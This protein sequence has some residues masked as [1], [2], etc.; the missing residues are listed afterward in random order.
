MNAYF[1]ILIEGIIL[2]TCIIAFLWF[3]L[4]D[5]EGYK[6]LSQEGVSISSEEL[7]GDKKKTVIGRYFNNR[8]K[9]YQW[10][11]SRMTDNYKYILAVYKKLNDDIEKKQAVPPSAEWLL[12]NFYVIDE[13]VQVIKRDLDKRSYLRLPILN[14]GPSKGHT[15]IYALAKDLVDQTNG[16]VD[17]KKFLH[18][19]EEYQSH[20]VLLEREIVAV[21]MMLKLALIEKIRHEC[22]NIQSIQIQWHKADKIFEEWLE[23]EDLDTKGITKLLSDN[24]RDINEEN[25][26]FIDHLFYHLRRSGRSYAGIIKAMDENF[27]KQGSTTE[28]IIQNEHNIQSMMTVSMS[29]CITSLHYF[30]SLNWADIFDTISFVELILKHDPDGT[31]PDMDPPTRSYYKTKVEELALRYNVSE[32]YI[33]NLAVQMALDAY[34]Q[35]DV[36]NMCETKYQKTWH[37]GHYLIGTGI[38]V[39][40]T[41]L[42]KTDSSS[43]TAEK[44]SGLRNFG[45]LYIGSV[46]LIT[47][48]LIGTAVQYSVISTTSDV[49]F[50]SLLAIIAVLIPASEIAVKMVNFV[51]SH[52]LKPS[53]FPKLELKDGIPES[54]ST[55][56]AVPTLIPNENRLKELLE[57][58]ENH[59]LSNREE[60]LYF[61]LI[62]A[63]RDSDEGQREDDDR[64]IG[65]A[66][67]GIKELNEKYPNGKKD[68]FY[69]FHRRSQFNEKNN[70]WIGWERKRGAIIEF[71]DL[72]LG[73]QD[74]S[75]AYSSSEKPPFLNTKYIITLD[76][77]T[78]LPNGMAKKM[79]GAM[80][81]P[82][83][84]PVIDTERGVV[85][86]GFGLM[87]PKIEVDNESSNKTHFARIFTGQ[88]GIDPYTFAVSDV[89]QD[90]FGEG[91]YNGKGIYDLRVF[92]SAMKDAICDDTVLSHDLLEGSYVRTGLVTD[93]KLI[94]SYPLRYNS[95]S[96]R[97]HRWVRGDWQ[98]IKFL[99]RKICNRHGSKIANPLS[100]LSRWKI[101]DNLRRSLITVSLMVLVFLSF[102]ILPGSI[103]FW[104]GFFLVTLAFPLIIG[105]IGY[106]ISLRFQFERIKN[107]MPL[108]HGIKALFMQFL[109]SFVFLPYQA[110]L[111]IKAISVTWVRVFIT[112]KNLLEWVTSDDIEKSQRNDLESYFLNMR[113]S[114]LQGLIVFLLT[115]FFKPELMLLGLLFFGAWLIAPVIAYWISKD[116]CALQ[117]K[118][119]EN[120]RH[121]L[122][123]IAR[124]TWRFFEEFTSIH[125][126]YL[127]PDNYQ[128][129]PPRCMALRTSP[130]NIGLGLMAVLCARDF[131][132][133][134]TCE[135]MNL[136]EKTIT[137]IEKM[138]KWNGHLYNWY[139][140]QTLRPLK[141]QY[142]STVDSG[143][144][145]CYLV[146]VSEG[147]KN[148]LDCPIVDVQFS[149]GIRDTLYC[150]GKEGYAAY[151]KVRA[152]HGFP[153][154]GQTNLKLWNQ[155]LNELLLG[156]G[157][158]DIPKGNWRTK[159]EQM[160]KTFKKDLQQ[161]RPGVEVME[162]VPDELLQK[163]LGSNFSDNMTELLGMLEHNS[164]LNNLAMVY[165]AK[166]RCVNRLISAIENSQTGDFTEGLAWLF[167]LEDKLNKVIK[168]TKQFIKRYRALIERINALSDA[169][170]FSPLYDTKR[171][172]F[173]IG[174]N[175]EENK[176]SNSYYDLLASEARQTSYICVAQGKIP[177]LHWYKLERSLTVMD[178][179]KGLISWTGTMFEYLM[180]L[181][182]MKSYK[183]TLLDETYSFVIRSQ[184]KYGHQK[185]M[186]WG[187]SESGFNSL[188][189][190]SD[191]QY[192]AIGVPWL[193][194][195]RGL[196]EDAV[197][198]PYATFLALQVDP[199]AAVKNIKLLK[200]EGLEG[201]YG[202]Y[203]AADYTADRLLYE[204]KRAVIKSFMSHHQGMS[205]V[206]LDNCLHKNIMQRRFHK[207]PEIRAA[208][209]LLQEKVASNIIFISRTQKKLV[210]HKELII[211]ETN[212]LR[213][214]T[215]PDP[216]LPNAHI[217]SNGNYSVMITD[218]GT[219]YSK[220]KLG[221]L[222]RWRE[223]STLDQYGMFF[224]LRN[225]ST[226]TVWSATYAPLNKMP[227]KY[228][229][230][231]TTDKATFRRLD[232]E[233]ETKT[234][235]IVASGDNVEIRR[236]TLK[237]LGE[238]SIVLELTSYYEVVMA[239][240]GADLAHPAF[241]N[242]FVETS[243]RPKRKCIVANRRPRLDT[244]NKMWMANAVVV[245]ESLLEDIQYETD[246][247]QM[248]GRGNSP[249]DPIVM[250]HEKPLTNTC[251]PVLDP[252][253]SIRVRVKIE[254]EKTIQIVFLN[255]VSENNETL[256]KLIDKYAMPDAIEEGFKL[257]AA[258]SKVEAEYLNMDATEM[259]LYQD[260]ISD[261]LFISPLKRSFQ[262]MIGANKQGQSS[263]W[264][265]GISGDLPV[266]VVKINNTNQ[267]EILY[268]ILKAHDYWRLKELRVDLVILSEEE[269]DY[270]LPL[271]HLIADFILASQNHDIVNKTGDIFIMDVKT[272]PK[273][274]INLL[275]AVARMILVGGG[276]TMTDQVRR[277]PNRL[278]PARRQPTR[279]P[280]ELLMPV[281]EEQELLFYNG[282][283]G[284]SLDGSK[285]VIQLKK[286]ENTP[287]PWCNI[288]ANPGFGFIVSEVGSGHTWYKNSRENKLTPWS[289][290]QVSDSS[291][292]AIYIV[293]E[294]S[295]EVWTVTAEPVRE[296]EPYTVSHGF[297][298][299]VFE[300]TS[301]GIKQ[302]L[303]QHVHV[304]ESVKISILNL[305][306]ESEL[307]RDLTLTYYIRPVMGVSDQATALHIKTSLDESGVLLIENPY[308]EEFPGKICFM[309]VSIRERSVSGDRN[310]FFG[311]G[312]MRLPESLLNEALSG[313][314]GTGFDPC[315]AIQVKITLYPN[316][317]KNVV[318]LLGMASNLKEISE[319][320]GKFTIVKNAKESLIEVKDF[321]KDKLGIV[322]V[323]TPTNSMNLMLNG[324]LQY[325][326]ISCR[327][328]ARSG[329][330]QSGGAFGFRDQLQDCLSIAHLWPEACRSQIL[331]HARH[332]YIEG[333]VQHWWHEPFGKGT[334]THFSDDRLWLPYVTAEY[335]RITGDWEILNE[336]IPFLE[337][338]ELKQFEDE[339]YGIPRI[340]ASTA[341]LYEHCIRA[342]EISLKF[343]NHGLPLMGSGD[344]NDGMNT[345]GNKGLGESIWLGWFLISNL[346]LF[347]PIC[348]ETGDHEKVEKYK[349]VKE[350]VLEAIETS[351]WDGNW[352]RRAYFDNGQVLGSNKNTE[353]MIDSIAQSWSVIS[354]AGNH[355]RA[356]QAMH[357]LE[358][359]LVS[360]EDGLIKL[361]TPPFEKSN[362]DPGY[363]K[364]YIPGVRENG[365]QYTHA[366]AWVIIAFAKLGDGDK[367]WELFE[368]INP[369]NHTEN[370]REYFR[371]KAEPY[372]VAADVYSV[373]PHTG[374]G[375]WTWYTGAAG[376]LYRAGLE[377][378][379]GFQK[380]GDRLIMDPCIPH[381]WKEYQ[382]SYN[383]M[384][385]KYEI[386]VYNPEGLS[387]GVKKISVDG[388]IS[389]GNVI[390]LIDDGKSHEVEVLMG[391]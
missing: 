77:D 196:I 241:S 131:G 223:D 262:D 304:E 365:G 291:G 20:D 70:K 204:N 154:A 234:E 200:E 177:A 375:G 265:Y 180:P 388:K 130:T 358:Q 92:Q 42:K 212:T 191:Y 109:L 324:W 379:L 310:E 31:Y 336:E 9:F 302:R 342:I 100:L 206:A 363:I 251:G 352:Y 294:E 159:I 10:P 221:M 272:I 330:Y 322:Q 277:S 64:I 295:Q 168:T 290:D 229:V 281:I 28:E 6:K 73:S 36:K 356:L 315:G 266:V 117:P 279:A 359:Y 217:L 339:R 72:V 101:F 192:K 29:N 366:A 22:E 260:M 155:A 235:I 74:T 21:P 199:E 181:L 355:D 34:R 371:Y 122:G 83:N 240:Q 150:A 111:M 341:S 80:A 116:Y 205:L 39:L 325:Q 51:I 85:V 254:S 143:N 263:L 167:E 287:L 82:L 65:A 49:L 27:V 37:V 303:T 259:E 50:Y 102:S 68:R 105:V 320:A 86:E 228:Q 141:P 313:A 171:E 114:L 193:G 95:Y 75:F 231:F 269:H 157:L 357:S 57:K 236:I 261:I 378:I 112:K 103:F 327:L 4:V 286:D 170:E 106:V 107:Y 203:E 140:I 328:W 121:E 118:I 169:M 138:E 19:M 273:E 390:N 98:L 38:D 256:L 252:V 90:L 195:K 149:N 84:R 33:S 26:Y 385:T 179:Y 139:D 55:I 198:A 8:R 63:F 123:R 305:K 45:F 125:T 142:I 197:T 144:L 132:F 351:G 66:L 383:Y 12:D 376:W 190:N 369:I 145:L 250:E 134:G 268:E 292:E 81:H 1:I 335:I 13:E 296:E 87:Q 136:I 54:L 41:T 332:Q 160:L 58:L 283:G 5:S 174:Y 129:D 119:S 187:T 301:H 249:I 280:L 44:R 210:P 165:K 297:G 364:G 16:Q 17:E 214:F 243:I 382:M 207:N 331:L 232:G 96:A 94:D 244:E 354:G 285:Y 7:E 271:Y 24:V 317:R 360:R 350:T 220:D 124:K 23:I 216:I 91:I 148:Y 218:R 201:P 230:D 97:L 224:Y 209:L 89:Y 178:H 307:K 347:I 377:Y 306:N 348:R 386:K 137:T 343:G 367:A 62:G 308:N 368:L 53:F 246:R 183:N 76:S 115:V 270:A 48:V 380:N 248:I 25:A 288:I 225:I 239:T 189:K 391:L 278:L 384:G 274:D 374:R 46:G 146:T 319:I 337:D 156:H 3:I 104:L 275:Y 2:I 226:N 186:P 387:K 344:W 147:L 245:N 59:Y 311:V 309:D 43:S 164:T 284:F 110:W 361:L 18:F 373:Y 276:G 173:S 185:R 289:N 113:A 370:F 166:M 40:E 184:K 126:H 299:S 161:F 372:V 318:F 258:R 312:D 60:N 162:K 314:T 215:K 267:M 326:V 321:W 176:L 108:M 264:R 158:E 14:S 208:Q 242:L 338:L 213:R 257:A 345:V 293:D 71:N 175:I 333:D 47:L 69:F 127:P 381:K 188:D 182:I 316:E 255:A 362:L 120:D 202:F 61:T 346:D 282:L 349:R 11:V 93:L 353:C 30:S 219:G 152:I 194:L 237:N 163:D 340:S 334:R 298:Y 211:E 233:I 15:R 253:M 389:M 78:A 329:F 133:I 67:A 128:E 135:M 300:H 88:E 238:K 32:L 222:T 153:C 35:C 56:V 323:K 172:L 99:N 79:I 151:E 52:A 247:M 227:E